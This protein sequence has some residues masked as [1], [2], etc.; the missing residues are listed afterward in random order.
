MHMMKASSLLMAFLF[1]AGCAQVKVYSSRPEMQ[2]IT[3]DYFQAEFEPQRAEGKPYYDSFRLVFRNK[4]DKDL[5]VDW[6]KSYYLRDGK[7]FGLFGWED[8][9]FEQLKE[10]KALPLVPVSP[11]KTYAILI[12]PLKLIAWEYYRRDS[13]PLRK[14]E[15]AFS[16][17]VIPEGKNGIRLY[18]MQDGKVISETM[19]LDIRME[20]YRK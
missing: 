9:T 3:N 18:V 5:I 1:L 6:S 16:P 15:E 12:F 17:G 11:G 20:T 8:M 14:P 7:R 13:T 19:N 2:D 4:T 10:A